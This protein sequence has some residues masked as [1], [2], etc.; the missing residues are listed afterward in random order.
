M[1]FVPL[2]THVEG[3]LHLPGSSVSHVVRCGQ[4]QG[5]HGRDRAQTDNPYRGVTSHLPNQHTTRV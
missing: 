4:R 2:P 3:A 5:D 1:P